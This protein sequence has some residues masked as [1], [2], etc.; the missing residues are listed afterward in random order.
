ML[1]LFALLLLLPVA[2][3]AQRADTVDAAT[4]RFLDRT[5]GQRADIVI[6]KGQV[7][8]LGQIQV[9]LSECRYP[10]SAISQDAYALL[11]IR[12]QEIGEDIFSGW[13]VASA[14]ALNALEHRR[15]DIW[16]LR[17]NAS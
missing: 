6:R 7:L 16:V 3:L 9:S 13:M 5:T 1:R 12:D 2:A 4:L 8:E 17:C 10:E 15:Y 11:T 14:P